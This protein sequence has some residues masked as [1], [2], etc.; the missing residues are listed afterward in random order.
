MGVPG[1]PCPKSGWPWLADP[2]PDRL[3]RRGE[4][5]QPLT[6]SEQ[7]E[8]HLEGGQRPHAA[9]RGG[10]AQVEG[11]GRVAGQAVCPTL[12]DDR[13]RRVD[14]LHHLQHA[15]KGI[16]AGQ[17]GRVSSTRVNAGQWGRVSSN[18]VNAGQWGRVAAPGPTF[19][20]A[21]IFEFSELPR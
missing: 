1:L 20:W 11:V 2:V 5:R 15:G 3:W 4:C 8:R 14:A 16:N 7:Q 13:L 19:S 9:G 10:T 12:A 17:W 6:S 21:I 18:G